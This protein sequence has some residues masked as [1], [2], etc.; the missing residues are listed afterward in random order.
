M[1]DP[2]EI[3]TNVPLA[4]LTTLGVGGP[5]RY[6]VDANSESVLLNSLA[7]AAER[8]WPILILGGGSNLLISDNGFDGMVIRIALAGTTFTDAGDVVD[9]RAAAGENWDELVEAC[10]QRGLAGI[11]C[12][13]GIPG[14]VGGTP[15][16]NVGAYGQEVAETIS[17]VRCLDRNR[18]ST[19]SLTAAQC[20]FAYRSSIFNTSQRE[21]YVVIEVVF[22]LTRNGRPN[23]RYKDLNAKFAGRS[24]VPSL[25]EVRDAVLQIRRAKSMVVDP[26]DP[27]S[28][29]AGS[30]FKNPI[31]S[32]EKLDQLRAVDPAVPAF[33]MGAGFKIPAAWLIEAAGFSKGF[34]IGRAGLSEN[35]SLAIVNRGGASSDDVIVLMRTI[36]DGVRREFGIELMPEPIFVGFEE[37]KIARDGLVV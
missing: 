21:R 33:D 17:S 19:V 31:V 12:L 25:E 22:R 8:G 6:F 14:L 9:V 20:G 29:S 4:P 7:T 1:I 24:D 28:R 5:A 26:R 36:Q 3:R 2:P 15:I 32:S 30:F 11:E 34:S 27:N 13:S 37:K 35:H 18:G 10:V 23:I 16:Q